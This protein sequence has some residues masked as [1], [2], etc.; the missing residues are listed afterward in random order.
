M[1]PVDKWGIVRVGQAD[2]VIGLFDNGVTTL[3]YLPT[4][5]LQ[6]GSDLASLR[7]QRTPR[8]RS[9]SC[10]WMATNTLTPR[11]SICRRRSPASI[12]ACIY[13]PNTSNGFGLGGSNNAFGDSITG[14]GTGTGNPCAVANCGCPSLS[15]GPGILDGA[16]ITNQMTFALRYQ[17]T[18]GGAGVYAYAAYGLSGHANYTGATTLPLSSGRRRFA[19]SKF[20]GQY[21]GLHFGNGGLAVTYGGFTLGGNV[22]GG[23]IS[24]V[25]APAPQGGASE[26]AYM[27]GTKYIAGPFTVGVAAERGDFQGNVALAGDQ[28]AAWAGDPYWRK[29]MRWHPGTWYMRTYQY[30]N[31][32]SKATSI[33][34][35]VPWVQAR[36]TASSRRGSS[37]AIW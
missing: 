3:Q 28:S 35:R 25:L 27:V 15:S 4:G 7:R 36:I 12:S 16:R 31:F 10:H 33:S 17:G 26:I 20:N 6:N 5:N 18:V 8:C 30:D 9:S 23:R 14:A 19:G 29:A 34:F 21:D 22:I 24:G 11:Q 32:S 13:A 1:S 37:S 2:G